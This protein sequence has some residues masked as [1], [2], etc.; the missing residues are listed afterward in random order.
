[1]IRA[2]DWKYIFMADGGREQL[3]DLK[4]DPNELVNMTEARRDVVEQL[5]RIAVAACQREEIESVLKDDTLRKF[6][7]E[8]RPLRR[9]YQF[10]RSRGITGFPNKPE[11]VLKR[12]N[13]NACAGK[14]TI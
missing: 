2:E 10:D 6:P 7:F 11:D 1:M 4:S 14:T 12:W 9:I 5:N 3:F 13:F 8:A